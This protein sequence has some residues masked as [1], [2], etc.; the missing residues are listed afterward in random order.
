MGPPNRSTIRWVRYTAAEM[1]DAYS[2]MTP[3]ATRRAR[4]LRIAIDMDEVIADSL[5]ELVRRYNATFGTQVSREDLRGRHLEDCVPVDHRDAVESMLDATFFED[6]VPLPGAQDVI[7]ELSARYE[8]FI[9]SAAMDVP[10]SFDAKCPLAPAALRVHP[11]VAHRVLR[12]QEHRRCRLPHRRPGAALR[13]LQRPA[14]AV[15][16][17]AQRR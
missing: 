13:S 2:P 4:Q 6:L 17:A 8:V 9:V 12:R 15:L 7:R 11:R 16:G 1:C 10:C 3:T 14:A 5:A